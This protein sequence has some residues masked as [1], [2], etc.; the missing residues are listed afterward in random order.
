MDTSPTPP[1]SDSLAAVMSNLRVMRTQLLETTAF[2]DCAVADAACAL[3]AQ[4]EATPA[5]LRLKAQLFTVQTSLYMAQSHRAEVMETM[6]E[7]LADEE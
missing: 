4:D 1:S 2:C 7:V 6:K 5:L 3:R